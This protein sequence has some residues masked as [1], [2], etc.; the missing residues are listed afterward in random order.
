MEEKCSLSPTAQHPWPLPCMETCFSSFLSLVLAPGSQL[1][2]QLALLLLVATRPASLPSV[3]RLWLQLPPQNWLVRSQRP[4]RDF[5]GAGDADGIRGQEGVTHCPSRPRSSPLSWPRCWC[6]V[7][8]EEVWQ[9]ILW[10]GIMLTKL[11]IETSNIESTWR[12]QGE[13]IWKW[14]QGEY[15]GREGRKVG[16]WFQREKACGLGNDMRWR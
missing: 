11:K 4:W 3:P 2:S 6:L 12:N 10:P 13:N 1:V 8:A 7:S 16:D 15:F 5:L 14:A 9:W